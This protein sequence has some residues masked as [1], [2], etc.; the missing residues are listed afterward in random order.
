MR[1][2]VFNKDLKYVTDYPVPRPNHDEALIRVTHAGICNTDIE[3]TRGYMGFKGIPGHEFVGVVERCSDKG[4]VGKRVAGEI[5]LGCGKCA[6]CRNQMQNHCS[7][8]SVLGILNKDG[9]FAEYVTLPVRNLHKIPKS[10]SDEEAVFIEP[11]AAVYEILDQTC[12]SSSDKVCV[13]GDGK[14]GLLAAQALAAAGSRVIAVGRHREKLSILDE[15][16]IHTGLSRDLSDRDFDIVIDCTGSP[17]GIR[18]ALQIVKPG[19]RIVLKTTTAK[20]VQIDMNQFVINE[21]S[22][23]GSRCGPFLP[24]IK[25][26][27]SRQIDLYPLISDVFPIEDGVKAFQHASSKSALKVILKVS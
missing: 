22:L 14:L 19:G 17:S 1:A 16:G 18:T 25:A 3:I 20:K 21:I 10:I 15:S 8:R 13:L 7:D 26:I 9:V 4:L 27:K 5:N 12:I 11:L 2:I 23:I 24:A 6:L